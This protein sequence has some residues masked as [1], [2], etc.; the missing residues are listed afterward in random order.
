MKTIE[1]NIKIFKKNGKTLVNINLNDED[2]IL[3]FQIRKKRYID[4][5]ALNLL[6]K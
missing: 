5:K 2:N 1:K 3:N 4:R 6:K